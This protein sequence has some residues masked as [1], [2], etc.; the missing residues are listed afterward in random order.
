MAKKLFTGRL[1]G[2]RSRGRSRQ[3]GADRVKTDLTVISKE[4]RIKD[5]EARDRWSEV[6]EAAKV[7]LNGL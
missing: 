6:V 2:K 4:I 3:R 1:N 5:S 7:V